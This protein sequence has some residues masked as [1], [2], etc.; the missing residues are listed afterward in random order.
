MAEVIDFAAARDR[1][2][3]RSRE[4]SRA[5]IACEGPRSEA[6]PEAAGRVMATKRKHGGPPA[7]RR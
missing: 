2:E 1:A 6:T 5:G 7:R 3:G 4:A